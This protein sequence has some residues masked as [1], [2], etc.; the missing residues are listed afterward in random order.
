M[1]TTLHRSLIA[2][3]AVACTALAAPAFAQVGISI[4]VH[5][6][7][8]YGRIDIG[9]AP[10]PPVVVQQPVVIAPG[11]VAVQ[12]RPIYLYVPPAYQ[13]DW[14]RYCGRYNACGQPVYFVQE[15][16]VRDRWAESHRPGPD[17]RDWDRDHRRQDMHHDDPHDRRDF[18]R[19]GP[20]DRGDH[21]R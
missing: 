21:R 6:P 2:L 19:D 18:R 5:E 9:G 17:R 3:G 20:P 8:V 7:G 11:P 13:H 12:Q 4:G 16:W 15:Q 1:K 14:R 10:P